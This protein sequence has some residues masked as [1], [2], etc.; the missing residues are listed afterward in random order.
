MVYVLFL[1][2]Y[3]VV[4]DA[5]TNG[6]VVIVEP[7]NHPLLFHTIKS[8]L[9]AMPF[10]WSGHIFY[11]LKNVHLVNKV[12]NELT[13]YHIVLTQLQVDDMNDVSLSYNTL[14]TSKYFWDEID[15]NTNGSHALIIQTDTIICSSKTKW[16]INDFMMYDYIGAP[17]HEKDRWV[18]ENNLP[19][20]VG[21]GGFSLRNISVIQAVL[22][23]F[24]WDEVTPEDIWFSYMLQMNNL[25]I[26][27]PVTIAETFAVE[28]RL[29]TDVID[30]Q[31]Q[32]PFGV[33]APWRY[34]SNDNFRTLMTICPEAKTLM[35]GSGG[36]SRD[37]NRDR[38][39]LH[40]QTNISTLM[41][42]S[43]I[44]Y[45]ARC[46]FGGLESTCIAAH[47]DENDD[48]RSSSS[49]SRSFTSQE[50]SLLTSSLP[51]LLLLKE[52]SNSSSNDDDIND[53]SSSG[54]SRNRNRRN[55]M[56]VRVTDISQLGFGC[57]PPSPPPSPLSPSHTP[58]GHEDEDEDKVKYKDTGLDVSHN[59]WMTTEN[60]YMSSVSMS[61]SVIRVV[62]RGK[63]SFRAKAELAQSYS[64]SNIDKTVIVAL[65]IVFDDSDVLS[66]PSLK[67]SKTNTADGTS[68]TSTTTSTPLSIPVVA[69]SFRTIRDALQ[70][71][72]DNTTQV[73]SITNNNSVHL[74]DENAEM[75]KGRGTDFVPAEDMRQIFDADI[76][77]SAPRRHWLSRRLLRESCDYVID[78][79]VSVSAGG[80]GRT[81]E[82]LR[83]V[84][85]SYNGNN[86]Y[87]LDAFVSI[88]I[89]QRV[90]PAFY[91]HILPILRKPIVLVTS[92][93]LS[94]LSA[95]FPM[96]HNHHHHNSSHEF[97]EE[98]YW[99]SIVQHPMIAHWY[100]DNW[101]MWMMSA[102]NSWTDKITLVPIGFSDAADIGGPGDRA[103]LSAAVRRAWNETPY[104]STGKR[105]I[106]KAYAN[107]HHSGESYDWMHPSGAFGLQ[108]SSDAR[109]STSGGSSRD[110][111]IDNEDNIEGFVCH[112][113]SNNVLFDCS[114]ARL[115]AFNE[116]S[117]NEAIYFDIP[118]APEVAWDMR[119]N[120][121]FEISPHGNGLDCHR[122]Y[123]ALALRMIPIVRTSPLDAMYLALELPVIIVD[124]WNEINT[125]FLENCAKK[126]FSLLGNKTLFGNTLEKLTLEWWPI[127]Y[128]VN[129]VYV[130]NPLSMKFS[131]HQVTPFCTSCLK[132][133]GE[134][135][136]FYNLYNYIEDNHHRNGEEVKPTKTRT[137]HLTIIIVK[138][139]RLK[140]IKDHYRV[141]HEKHLEPTPTMWFTSYIDLIFVQLRFTVK[142]LV[143]DVA[144]QL[145]LKARTLGHF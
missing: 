123:E 71:I 141:P 144:F 105:C 51:L 77:N 119:S 101:N 72:M 29:S 74:V 35:R 38:D 23:T 130:V 93:T 83:A 30:G 133:Y 107:F 91:D 86:S 32:I 65:V 14:L 53:M 100:S 31:I 104:N 21:N 108:S 106:H 81:L 120:F 90:L 8:V 18:V 124:H 96:G 57:P 39:S 78:D 60:E 41:Y 67:I 145:D 54:R 26:V 7:R 76:I 49:S 89:P 45:S 94:D 135:S 132:K 58:I 87:G 109:N 143:L 118:R 4:I 37:R 112:N 69:V 24:K 42:G 22:N 103:L 33:H 80:S 140:D 92:D 9:E 50:E 68:S 121:M 20:P 1:L 117:T 129:Q 36:R 122:T 75:L 66:P 25:G 128:E 131:R 136:L 88:A 99:R 55:V 2:A 110:T 116:L 97:D 61:V 19:I 73:E 113:N 79:E 63:C 40:I 52:N 115:S 12:K 46:I 11:G 43:M 15:K 13:K 126:Y 84:I 95:P 48:P 70:Q 137:N 62:A 56:R 138:T 10:P 34:L 3:A 44:P 5:I 17:W 98:E 6:V 102:N 134:Q 82:R 127:A 64:N 28:S 114:G 142:F 111:T 59:N 85:G 16:T 47:Y 139:Q 27:A 125:S